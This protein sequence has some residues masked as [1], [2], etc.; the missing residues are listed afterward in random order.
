MKPFTEQEM[1]R[2][3]MAAG[4]ETEYASYGMDNAVAWVTTDTNECVV[5]DAEE[6]TICVYDV[7]ED[8][9]PAFDII[10]AA[11]TIRQILKERG[12]DNISN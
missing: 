8:Y 9:H 10:P 5:Y 3:A 2:V 12:N 7:S 11:D 4:Y 6:K 1:I